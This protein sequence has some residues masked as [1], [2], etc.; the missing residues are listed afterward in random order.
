MSIAIVI[1]LIF[2]SWFAVA[3]LVGQQRLLQ[4]L[5][6]PAVPGIVLVL[7]A[8]LLIG[9]FCLTA[10]REWVHR[11]DLRGLVLIHVSRLIGIYFL[12]LYARGELPYAFAV[13][14]GVG[15]IIV[16]LFALLVVFLPVGFERRQH[17][18]YIWNV[19]GF[20]DIML[21]VVTAAYFSFSWPTQMRALTR[22]PLSLLP[23]FLVPLIIATHIVI[24][25]R[26]ARARAAT[27]TVAR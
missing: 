5:P 9:Y 16:A 11:L 22:L 14:G 19:V 18:I 4:R 17:L 26:I 24:F 3:V 2:W 1:R 25:A 20:I 27:T 6:P 21:I 8:L 23:T 10:L 12:A 13:P 7:T 15:D